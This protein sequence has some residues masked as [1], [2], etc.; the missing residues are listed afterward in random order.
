[1]HVNRTTSQLRSFEIISGEKTVVGQMKHRILSQNFLFH[2]ET[3]KQ[4]NSPT[5]YTSQLLYTFQIVTEEEKRTVTTFH[6][7]MK[8]LNVTLN[9]REYPL[10]L[11]SIEGIALKLTLHSGLQ[12]ITIR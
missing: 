6:V 7:A 1:M 11:C 10:A 4:R 12:V 9:K 2:H 5:S 8:E 3:N